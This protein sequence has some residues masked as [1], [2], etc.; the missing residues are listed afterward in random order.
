MRNRVLSIAG[1][2]VVGLVLALGSSRVEAQQRSF[3][4]SDPHNYPVGPIGGVETYN[5]NWRSNGAAPGATGNPYTYN[6]VVPSFGYGYG[7]GSYG[8][9]LGY[10]GGGNGGGVTAF[11]YAYG[12]SGNS[13]V[14][15][16]MLPSYGVTYGQNVTGFGVTGYG[17]YS[18]QSGAFGVPFNRAYGGYGYSRGY[19]FVR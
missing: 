2:L 14:G 12:V 17:S 6:R 19:G 15:Y 1:S 10:G 4:A 16:I 9:G 5:P 7:G 18:Q 11:P 13:G 8:R 3:N